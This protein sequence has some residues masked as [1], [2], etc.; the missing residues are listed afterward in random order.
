[1]KKEE[2]IAS[3]P[4][5]CHV[6]E[7]KGNSIFCDLN[8][9]E[10]DYLDEHKYHLK[11]KSSEIIFNEGAYPHGVFCVHKGKVKIV[12]LGM[13]GKEQ[14]L[15]LVHAG[16]VI[17]YKSMLNNEK[18]QTSAVALEETEV[19]FISKEAFCALIERN[20][21]T[22]MRIVQVLVKDL[23]K[24]DENIMSLAQKSL[25]ERVAEALVVLKET[26]GFQSDGL[27]LD[28]SISRIEMA[29][30][31]GTATESVIRF[32]SE[33]QKDKLIALENKKIKIL[34]FQKLHK[35]ANLMD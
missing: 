15:R 34:D 17:G 31:V 1:M 19:C 18:Y 9:Q 26:Y 11:Y 23:H 24:A 27:T 3:I 35:L 29:N 20:H 32:L 33:F 28:L 22:S 21:K 4:H 5:S 10:T 16:D 7:Y 6:C 25:R 2:S 13:N 30:L 8:K 12:K 14:I